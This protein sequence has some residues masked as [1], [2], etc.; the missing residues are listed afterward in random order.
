MKKWLVYDARY[1][2]DEDRAICLIV[3]N[4][5]KEARQEAPEYGD[6]NVIVEATII[7]KEIVSEKIVN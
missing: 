3:C 4:S 5:L 6:G 1:H 2:T 7:G